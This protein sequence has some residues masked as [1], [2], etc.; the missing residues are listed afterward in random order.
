MFGVMREIVNNKYTGTIYPEHARAL[1]YDR[2][3]GPIKGYPGGGGYAGDVYD[4]A[5][6]RAMLQ[7]ALSL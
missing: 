5:Y 4:V 2:E 3:R 1:D 6:T 7:A